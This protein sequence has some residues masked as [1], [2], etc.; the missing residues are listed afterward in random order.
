LQAIDFKKIKP[1]RNEEHEEGK[2]CKSLKRSGFSP[3][4]RAL[5]VLRGEILFLDLYTH[6]S[7]IFCAASNFGF[8]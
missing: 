8:Y 1:Q 3:P 2:K 4:L 6:V 5:G 7:R